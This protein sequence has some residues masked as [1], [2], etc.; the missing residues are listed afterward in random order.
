MPSRVLALLSAVCILALVPASAPAAPRKV[1]FKFSAITY[2]VV[3]NVGTFNVTVVRSGNTSAAA[4]IAY[5]DTGTG[6]AT[7]GG[8][9]YSFS[10]GT[11]SFAAGQTSKTFP[12]TIVDNGTANAPNKTIV[13]KLANATP[14]GSDQDHDRDADD[15]RQRGAGHARLQLELLHRPRRRRRRDHH[16]EPHRRI[17]PQAQR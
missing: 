10:G 16:G 12:V 14:A 11:L 5:S 1:A 8:T 17:E 3:E 2:S 15:H 9:D 4:S 6:T 7:G 13:F